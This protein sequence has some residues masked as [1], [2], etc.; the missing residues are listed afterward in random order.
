MLPERPLCCPF[1]KLTQRLC[2]AFP[3]TIIGCS[4]LKHVYKQ[5]EPRVTASVHHGRVGESGGDGNQSA[6]LRELGVA[7]P[8]FNPEPEGKRSPEDED[9]GDEE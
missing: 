4:G 3:N 2:R 8:A 1:C 7:A 9:E 6:V 5:P